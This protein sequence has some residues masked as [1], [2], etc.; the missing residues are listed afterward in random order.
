M[1]GGVVDGQAVS[2]AVTDPAFIYKNADDST[3]YKLGL[4][5]PAG[6]SGPI[7]YDDIQQ[8]L[9]TLDTATGSTQSVPG[10]TYSAPANTVT[11]GDNYPT[12]IKDLADKFDPTTGHTHDG[13]AGNGPKISGPNID[14]VPLQGVFQQGVDLSAVTGTSSN[15]TTQLAG[16]PVS[17]GITVEGVVS[18]APNNKT[19]LR[20][21]SNDQEIVDASGNTVYGRLTYSSGTWTQSYYSEIAG[22]ETAYTFSATDVRWYYQE[23]FNPFNPAFPTY[24]ELAIIPSD[25]VTADVIPATT[26]LQGKVLLSSTAPADIASAGAAGTANATVANANHTHKGVA[27]A[28][29]SAPLY[30]AVTFTGG[31]GITA[32]QT[33]QQIG[34]DLYSFPTTH[35]TSVGLP[36]NTGPSQFY[37]ARVDQNSGF[38]INY[39]MSRGTNFRA[40][41]I[42]VLTDGT[43]PNDPAETIE[44]E[45]GDCGVTWTTSQSVVAGHLSVLLNFT[46]T[47]TGTAA[48]ISCDIYNLT[49]P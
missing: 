39:I 25:N 18:T 24:S 10:T 16:H 17:T 46:T 33:G 37:A 8:A 20:K 9:N 13:T 27:S 6:G 38:F 29:V 22:V 26:A 30:G 2:A 45:I 7:L 23:L 21:A 11:D 43:T 15:V 12:A 48:K 34:F 36:D 44:S 5:N 32:S 47:S 49:T 14:N 41:T 28:A 1:A 35:A 31:N 4:Q 3:I 19:V 40:G 42:W